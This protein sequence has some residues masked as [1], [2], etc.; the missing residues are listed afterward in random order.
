MN[1][2]ARRTGTMTI[3]IGIIN[4]TDENESPQHDAGRGRRVDHWRPRRSAHDRV[5]RQH[6][7]GSPATLYLWTAPA[8]HSV[9]RS[10]YS[11]EAHHGC[12]LHNCVLTTEFDAVTT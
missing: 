6:F 11:P 5:A 7:S 1:I 3:K 9:G 12:P 10:T 8:R 2:C 4:E